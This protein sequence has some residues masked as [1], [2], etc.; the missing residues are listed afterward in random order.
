MNT[1]IITSKV[2][3]IDKDHTVG[4]Y[5]KFSAIFFFFSDGLHFASHNKW[6]NNFGLLLRISHVSMPGETFKS[7]VVDLAGKKYIPEK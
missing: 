6:G 2:L 5:V 3:C 4:I 1:S 7:W